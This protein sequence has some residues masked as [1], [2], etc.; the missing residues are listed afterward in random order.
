MSRKV[1]TRDEGRTEVLTRAATAI[2]KHGYHGMTM[3]LLAKATGR[4]LAGF[5]HLFSS[6]EEI[7]F[8]LH[9]RAFV[10]LLG[11]ARAA[12]EG[13]GE[14]ATAAQKLH[15]FVANHVQYVIEQPDIMRVLVQEASALPPRR[16]AVIRDLKERYFGLGEALVRG[17]IEEGGKR[18]ADEEIERRA[19]CVFGM[20]NWLF[21][22]FDAERHG[23]P[24][25]VARSILDVAVSGVLTAPPRRAASSHRASHARPPLLEAH[26]DWR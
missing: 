5:Y 24:D 26:G 4:S 21:G 8:E 1:G 15:R 11:S 17:V 18:L 2:A 25:D 3:R 22:W 20:L 13:T 7:L 6:K 16:R 9:Q 14:R 23:S 12:V 19:Y 10:H